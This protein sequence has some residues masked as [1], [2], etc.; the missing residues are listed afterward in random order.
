MIP[1]QLPLSKWFPWVIGAGF[2]V[3][4]LLGVTFVVEYGI[5]SRQPYWSSVIVGCT[6][7]A[8]F[9]LLARTVEH[10][11]ARVVVYLIGSRLGVSAATDLALLLSWHV[12]ALPLFVAVLVCDG[13]ILLGCVI[14]VISPPA[15]RPL[16]GSTT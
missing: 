14:L 8:Y 9:I 13:F 4:L 1:R 6:I 10:R 15:P 7:A 5:Q 12:V 16:G 2:A 3:D 11:M